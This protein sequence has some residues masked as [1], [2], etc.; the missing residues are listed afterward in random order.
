MTAWHWGYPSEGLLIS[1]QDGMI[2][3]KRRARV[4][5]HLKRCARCRARA[6]QLAQDWKDFAELSL[7]AAAEP[8]SVQEELIAKIQAS[9]HAWSEANLPASSQ[10]EHQAFA[11]TE[12]DRRIADVLGIYL[13]KR[14]A[15]AL[16]HAEGA[17][18]A[19]RQESLAH[20]KSA[21]RILLGRKGATAVEEKLLKIMNHLPESSGGSTIS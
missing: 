3:E 2:S 11:Q 21:L 7:S 20:A 5:R 14:A 16:F 13:G 8:S 1:L 6:S 12:T 19:S 9:I 17:S 10:Q 4:E 15:A 18:P